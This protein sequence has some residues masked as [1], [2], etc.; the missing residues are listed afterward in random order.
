MILNLKAGEIV[1]VKSEAEIRA[2]LDAHGEYESVPFMPEMSKFC[3][4][5]FI[6][7]KRA[8]KVCAESPYFHMRRMENAVFL[9]GARCDGQSHDGCKRVCAIFWKEEWLRRADPD[10]SV[11]GPQVAFWPAVEADFGP[12]QKEKTYICQSTR[13]LDGSSVLS[14]LDP[15]QYVRDIRNKNFTIAQVLRYIYIYL[16]NKA[17]YKRGGQEFGKV[18]GDL[19]KTPVISLNLQPGELVEVKS[20]EE[21]ALTVDRRGNNRGLSIDQEMLQHSGKRFRVLT[22]VDRIILE[23]N[24]KMKEIRD[25]V[26]LSE[27]TCGGLCKRGCTRGLHPMWR[28]AWLK[29]VEAPVEPT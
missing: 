3:G 24:G 10:Q 23:A 12:V 29:R 21:I 25:T 26:A 1:E 15:R 17:Q 14:S 4:K 19:D 22:R 20:R 7:Y 27:V 9:E 13:I 2:T 5:R 8:D 18:V 16:F 11:D 6:V 28:E